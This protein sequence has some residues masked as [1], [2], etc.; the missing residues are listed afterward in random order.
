MTS[1]RIAVFIVMG[2]PSAEH[3]ISLLSGHAALSELDRT[4]YSV[5]AIVISKTKEIFCAVADASV[6]TIEELTA[7]H[8]S[9]RFTSPVAFDGARDIW[10]RC[11]IALLVTHGEFGEDGTLQGY[12]E[13]ID[14]PYTGSTVYASAVAMNK[15]TTKF[16]FQQTGLDV[17]AYSIVGAAHPDVTVETIAAQ[18]GFPVFVKCPQSGSS[19]LMG[20]ANSQK[21]L[22]DLL[23]EYS[24]EAAE[25]L[26]ERTIVGPEFSCAVIEHA[27]GKIE[28]LPPIEIRPKGNTFFD[29]TAKYTDNASEEICPAPHPAAL[30]ERIQDA[31]IRA[32]RSCG[33]SGISRTD[34]L[35]QDD[36]LY[37]LEINTLP[38]LTR[39]SLLPKA[40]K[41]TGRGEYP[42]LLDIMIGCAMA[43]KPIQRKIQ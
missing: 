13:A 43:K 1:S 38:G 39:N 22:H 17:P 12:L 23:V 34:M 21:E 10:N 7:P 28:A 41:A 14:V 2:G 42:Q 26:V 24:T 35:L 4:K 19:R 5:T 32:H 3:A 30:L 18:H 8:T 16:L 15:I 27:D 20:K 11:D 9:S 40:F 33:C 31:A 37:V 6:P 36:T 25:I 29:F